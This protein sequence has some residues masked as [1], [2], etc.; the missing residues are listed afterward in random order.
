[1]LI[2]FHILYVFSHRNFA[3]S[4]SHFI[5]G[6]ICQTVFVKLSDLTRLLASRMT[7]LGVHTD[8]KSINRMRL[9]EQLLELRPGLRADK[10]GREVFLSFEENVG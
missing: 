7:S 6:S 3:E 4:N 2:I 1:M 10:A 9:K 8:E 5:R